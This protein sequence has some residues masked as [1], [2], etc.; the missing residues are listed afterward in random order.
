MLRVALIIASVFVTLASMTAPMPEQAATSVLSPEPTAAPWTGDGHW[1]TFQVVTSGL[2]NSTGTHYLILSLPYY[3]RDDENAIAI[4][5][6]KGAA[7]D[8]KIY[9]CDPEERVIWAHTDEFW[10]TFVRSGIKLPEPDHDNS[11]L[12]IS[13]EDA[14]LVLSEKARSELLALAEE[15]IISGEPVEIALPDLGTIITYVYH[16]MPW[17]GYW[18]SLTIEWYHNHPALV[19]WSSDLHTAERTIEIDPTS[20]LYREYI[21]LQLAGI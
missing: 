14:S 5:K 7:K 4:G 19:S 1:Y 20:A 10:G 15:L 16:D 6:L 18:P 21:E 12:M 17:L 13:S 11:D 3:V 9:T 8:L 2:I